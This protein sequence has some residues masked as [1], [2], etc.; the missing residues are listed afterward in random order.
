MFLSAFI[1]S[2]FERMNPSL[3]L[4]LLGCLINWGA[5]LSPDSAFAASVEDELTLSRGLIRGDAGEDDYFCSYWGSPL[6][7]SSWNSAAFIS[8]IIDSY[9]P[10]ERVWPA[11]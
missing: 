7:S 6:A 3:S 5:V 4:L 11:S 8:R 2:V 10:A 9:L 1:K